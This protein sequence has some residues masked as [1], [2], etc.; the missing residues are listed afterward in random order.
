MDKLVT[1]IISNSW[2]KRPI[3]QI[4]QDFLLYKGTQTW[5]MQCILSIIYNNLSPDVSRL[6]QMLFRE[7]MGYSE[8]HQTLACTSSGSFAHSSVD[9]QRGSKATG[10]KGGSYL[11]FKSESTT[12]FSLIECFELPMAK[13]SKGIDSLSISSP[14]LFFLLAHPLILP[15]YLSK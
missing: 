13:I 6:Y 8:I 15:L 5:M 11:Q 1:I 9:W 3:L 4:L 14:A 7:L 12:P 10:A 2:S